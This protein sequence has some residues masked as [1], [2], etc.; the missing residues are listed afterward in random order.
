MYVYSLYTYAF[1]T[2]I[3]HVCA[4][5]CTA[6]THTLALITQQKLPHKCAKIHGES[7]KAD[8]MKLSP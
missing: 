3:N 6:I 4:Y 7:F 1:V 5:V 2:K 8:R